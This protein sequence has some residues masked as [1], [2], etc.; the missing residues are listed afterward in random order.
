MFDYLSCN[1]DKAKYM[2]FS[3]N[4]YDPLIYYSHIL[5]LVVSLLLAFFVFIN[6]RK[7]KINLSFFVLNI[8]FSIWVGFDLILWSSEK[9]DL[10]MFFWSIIVPIEL[11]VFT[12]SVIFSQEF[13]NLK[14]FKKVNK[15]LIPILFIPILLFTH[16]K[17]NLVAFDYTNCDRG[18][19]EG[20]LITYL[21]AVEILMFV[22]LIIDFVYTSFRKNNFIEKRV[23][24][25]ASLGILIFLGIFIVGNL[26]LLSDMDWRYEQYKLFGMP[27]F[28]AVISFLIVRFK[29][30]NV[31]LLGAQA[32]VVALVI[33]IGSQFLFIRTNINRVLTSVAL[34]FTGAIGISLIRSV[35]KEVKAR[36]EIEKREKQLEIVNKQL[37]IANEGQSN[38]LHFITHQVKGYFTKSRNVF[39][40]LKTG[41]YGKL[42]DQAETMIFE[43]FRSATEGVDLVQNVLNAANIDRGTM[44]YNK[45]DVDLKSILRDVIRQKET[46]ATEKGLSIK[47]NIGDGNF[48]IH[49]DSLQLKEVM[50]NL[51]ENAIRYTLKG[52]L[53]VNLSINDHMILFY[54]K[55]TG[56]GVSAEDMPKLFKKGG[57]GTDSTKINPE[58]TGYGLYIVKEIVEKAHGGRVWVES[59]G[60]G[61]GST[62][63]VQLPTG[64]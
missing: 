14:L 48:N 40:E 64:K 51:I 55:D 33:L 43:G 3:D 6:N 8:C 61:K 12:F 35:K 31:K 15:Y 18:A 23:H 10:I 13:F 36:E 38:L 30:F 50:K 11:L 49:G 63:F 28:L 52:G 47:T 42:P 56:V 16:T 32:L 29:A 45:E 27:I 26:S 19:I 46:S 24:F 37:E 41:E 21:Y 1:W 25:I 54:V 5:P 20:V 2:F 62:F 17:F 4:V 7:S 57:H 39:A 60:K 44:K 9:P 34:V 53:E 22:M 59:E 58:S